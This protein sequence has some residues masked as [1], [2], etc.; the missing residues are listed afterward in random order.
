MEILL[1]Y[2]SL[3]NI[4]QIHDLSCATDKKNK[5]QLQNKRANATTNQHMHYDHNTYIK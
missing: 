5:K 4:P 2:E 3:L 1:Y